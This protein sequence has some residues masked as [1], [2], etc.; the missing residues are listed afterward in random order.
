MRLGRSLLAGDHRYPALE[1][2]LRREP[3]ARLD[4]DD[5]PRRDEGARALARRP[6][7]RDPGAARL[8]QDVDLRPADR[9]PDRARQARR[10]RLD[11]P[12]GDPQPARGGRGGGR[13]DRARAST[14]SRRRA[15]GNPESFYD[16]SSRIENVTDAG[17]CAD[18]DLAAG[19]AWLFSTRRARQPRSTTSSSTRPAR[20]RSPT[21]S[22]WAPPPGTSCS[23]ATRSSSTR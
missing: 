23:S 6:A 13:R 1:S 11:E 2:V 12:Q 14:G 16:G 9:A 19:T 10:R 5:R 20:S 8:G 21:R 3:F 17:D 7:S 18:C 22:R 15:R 4:P